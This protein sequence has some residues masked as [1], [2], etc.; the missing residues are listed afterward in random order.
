MQA[1][2]VLEMG[3]GT[4]LVSIPKQWAVKNRIVKGSTVSVD[5]ISDRKLLVSPI[6]AG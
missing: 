6:T 1:R 5:E 3:G 2:K 4:L